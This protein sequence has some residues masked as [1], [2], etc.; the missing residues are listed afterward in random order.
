M[1]SKKFLTL[2]LSVMLLA[3][4]YLA[5]AQ[6]SIKPGFDPDLLIADERFA[7]T[8]TFGGAQGIQRFLESKRSPLADT[9]PAF[10]AR[11]GEPAAPEFK[12]ALGDLNPELARKRSAAELIWDASRTAGINPQ[13]ILT[14]LQKEQGL[15]TGGNTTTPERIQRALDH[16]MG[17][18]CPDSTGCGQLFNGFYFQLFGNVDT[19]NNRYLGSARSLMKSFSAPAG[20]G[21]LIGGRDSRVGDTITLGNTLGGFEGVQPQQSVVLRSRA[22]AALYRYTPHVFNGNYNF[23]R[24]FTDWFKY[25]NGTLVRV[26]GDDAVYSIQSGER[27]RVL[28]FVAKARGLNVANAITI[29]PTEV[30]DYPAGALYGPADDTIIEVASKHYVFRDG[31]K[32]PASR[33]VLAQRKLDTTKIVVVDASEAGQFPDGT[34]LTPDDG[35][36]LR[37]TTI[38]AAYRVE[39]GVLKRF[40]PFTFNQLNAAKSLKY[41]PDDELLSYAKQGWVAPL[42]DTLVKGP[43]S[44]DVYLMGQ[45]QKLP[46]AP[47][48]FKNRGFSL[49]KV[50][51][52]SADEIGSFATGVSPT[53][54]E[55]TYF[56]EVKSK[57]LY[58]FKNGAKHAIPKFV[59]KQRRITADFVF[60]DSIVEQWPN[61]IAVPPRDGTL[62]KG[63]TTPMIY[64]VIDGQLRQLTGE[65]FKNRGYSFRNVMTVPNADV[66]ILPKAGFAPPREVTYFISAKAKTLYV[67]KG[68]E[69]HR[70]SPFVA[71]QRRITPD[72]TID[73]ATVEQWP[74][75]APLPPRDY[76]IVK[77][78]GS[79]EI[80][81]VL[82]G[83]LRLLSEYAI[84]HRYAAKA[85]NAVVLPQAEIEGYAKGA[86]IAK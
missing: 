29:S 26:P 4:P 30:K 72:F 32:H 7:D 64:V 37:G 38:E 23:W 63:D 47:A 74:A 85:K 53:P 25:G 2:I 21:P 84:A 8:Q 39:G 65:T 68:G 82:G 50:V 33:F 40:S 27:R 10:L 22:T 57:D 6:Q 43:D 51:T 58:V 71:K 48:L 46:L 13:V 3:Q 18:D 70:I 15:V 31:I 16:A 80:Y 5:F 66:E 19:E 20:R 86:V 1:K 75:G 77:G 49:K 12:R 67:Y 54:R 11:L 17:F 44:S 34:Q 59:A 41:V 79:P 78:D 9:S 35:T 55:L 83:K 56:A 81:E 24:F 36:I 73:D 52:L 45:G 69:R 14:T 61:G 42:D 62:V 76:T 60:D 28:G